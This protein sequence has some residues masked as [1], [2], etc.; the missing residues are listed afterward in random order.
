MVRYDL[1]MCHMSFAEMLFGKVVSF[2][3]QPFDNAT[4]TYPCCGGLRESRG[5]CSR[6]Q[7]KPGELTQ[8][9]A[10][11]QEAIS[12]LSSL[13]KDESGECAWR[14]ELTRRVEAMRLEQQL[15]KCK[16]LWEQREEQK[17]LDKELQELQEKATQTTLDKQKLLEKRRQ[18]ELQAEREKREQAQRVQQMVAQEKQRLAASMQALSMSET[19]H[20]TR[21]ERAPKSSTV[22]ASR[23]PRGGRHNLPDE[24]VESSSSE[25]DDNGEMSEDEVTAMHRDVFGGD[26]DSEEEEQGPKKRVRAVA[27]S[28][29][30]EEKRPRVE[31]SNEESNGKESHESPEEPHKEA[32]QEKPDAH[33]DS[34]HSSEPEKDAIAK[35]VDDLFGDESDYIVCSRKQFN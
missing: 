23:A 16:G 10:S 14:S 2:H 13:Q 8:A 11:L 1:A 27:S 9:E 26:S 12:I 6:S 21:R 25:T 5:C 29:D 34:D 17:Q 22:R 7:R 30:E 32:S 15:V 19:A 33:A 20:E 28:D 31:E 18:E 4:N 24:I 35:E 3:K